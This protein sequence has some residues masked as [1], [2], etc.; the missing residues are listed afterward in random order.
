MRTKEDIINSIEWLK[1]EKQQLE[2]GDNEDDYKEMLND[3][4]PPY[5]VG[6]CTFYFMQGTF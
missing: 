2:D 1:D 4:Y 6:C 5:Q 3:S